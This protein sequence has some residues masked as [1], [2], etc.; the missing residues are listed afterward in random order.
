[1]ENIWHFSSKVVDLLIIFV[2]IFYI[3]VHCFIFKICV[4]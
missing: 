2:L 1:V 4:L 3:A